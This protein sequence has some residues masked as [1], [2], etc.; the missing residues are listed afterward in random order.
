M[1]PFAY[2]MFTVL[3]TLAAGELQEDAARVE[4][5]KLQGTWLPVSYVADGMEK[6]PK[7]YTDHKLIIEGDKF[8]MPDRG[9]GT[10]TIDPTKTPKIIDLQYDRKPGDDKR[11]R[12]ILGVYELDGDMLKL[13][14]DQRRPK[15]F[16][17]PGAGGGSLISYKRAKP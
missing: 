8:S 4:Q 2:C 12:P 7:D 5:D 13:H 11:R 15:D 10:F 17:P 3:L 16:T 14:V 6:D 1:K 9:K